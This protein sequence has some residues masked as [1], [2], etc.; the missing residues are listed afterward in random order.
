MCEHEPGG[1]EERPFETLN[2]ADVAGDAAVHAAVGRVA[3]DRVADGAQV[4]ANLV[5]ASGSIRW[6]APSPG[7]SRRW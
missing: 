2:S 3:D 5:R 6:R 1:V 4:D 7:R